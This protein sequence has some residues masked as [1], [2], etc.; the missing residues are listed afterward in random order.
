MNL[1]LQGLNIILNPE[2][3][4]LPIIKMNFGITNSSKRMTIV[5]YSL[6]HYPEFNP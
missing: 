5:N 6:M 4:F 3:S 1:N 2:F